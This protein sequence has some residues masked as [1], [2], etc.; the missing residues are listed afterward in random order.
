MGFVIAYYILHQYTF[1]LS[2]KSHEAGEMV[3]KPSGTEKTLTLDQNMTCSRF[4]CGKEKQKL[5]GINGM[6]VPTLFR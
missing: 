2:Y 3:Y 1:D 5:Y 6:P 4:L